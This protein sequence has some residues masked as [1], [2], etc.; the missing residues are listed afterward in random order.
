MASR[1]PWL[2]RQPGKSGLFSI[3]GAVQAAGV[4]LTGCPAALT[5]PLD[6]IHAPNWPGR[7]V[8]TSVKVLPPGP[9]APPASVPKFTEMSV[10]SAGAALRPAMA[11]RAE[12]AAV[13]QAPS[14]PSRRAEP[15]PHAQGCYRVRDRLRCRR[16]RA[17][18][19]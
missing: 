5:G 9:V 13:R 1:M 17:R 19:L 14:Q 6:R 18:W 8:A 16:S 2:V 12:A 11:T 7:L 3:D 15:A 10:R 4:V